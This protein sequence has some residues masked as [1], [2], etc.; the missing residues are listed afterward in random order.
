MYSATNN[1]IGSLQSSVSGR[2]PVQGQ[3][4]VEE[5]EIIFV[6]PEHFDSV[7]DRY[8]PQYWRTYDH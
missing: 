3:S 4:S 6:A 1:A 5:P 7:N 2:S 8:L